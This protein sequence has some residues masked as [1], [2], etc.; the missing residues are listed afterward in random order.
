MTLTICTEHARNVSSLS[1][2]LHFIRLDRYGWCYYHTESRVKVAK[3]CLEKFK[4][5]F[6]H[7]GL[8]N[9]KG[10][11]Q[12]KQI[13][14]IFFF[15]LFLFLLKSFG[16]QINFFSRYFRGGPVPLWMRGMCPAFFFVVNTMGYKVIQNDR[17]AF[18]HVNTSW[19]FWGQ[20]LIAS[21][22]LAKSSLP[23]HLNHNVTTV[24][25]PVD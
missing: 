23:S 25:S 13:S 19:S 14:T 9:K 1:Y 5:F 21:A 11:C 16:T 17:P 15:I 12:I 2:L 6:L 20:A 4:I 3:A 22:F 24:D 18:M 10:G 7:F 8:E